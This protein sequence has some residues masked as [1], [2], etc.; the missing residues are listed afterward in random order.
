MINVCKSFEMKIGTFD[1]DNVN[2]DYNNN[3]L[4]GLTTKVPTPIIISGH[5]IGYV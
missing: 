2:C 1:L 4:C 3:I 5:L